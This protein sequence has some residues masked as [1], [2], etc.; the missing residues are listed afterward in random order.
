MIEFTVED[1]TCG[2]CASFITMAVSEV[3][4]TA[5]CE[6][7]LAAKKVR[8]RSTQDTADFETAISEAGYTPVRA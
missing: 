5:K 6:V 8:I 7:D 1:M 2:H 3:D 4:A